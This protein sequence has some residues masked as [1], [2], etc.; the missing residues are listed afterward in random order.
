MSYRISLLFMFLLFLLGGSVVLLKSAGKQATQVAVNTSSIPTSTPTIVPTPSPSTLPSPSP[1]A[2]P[3]ITAS[4]S[5]SNQLIAFGSSG[6]FSQKAPDG[7]NGVESRI[8][9]I[10]P[11]TAAYNIPIYRVQGTSVPKVTITNTYSG[12]TVS[13]PIPKNAQPATGSDHTLAVIDQQKHIVYMMWNARWEGDHIKAGGMQEF[14]LSGTGI[15]PKNQRV[16]ASGFAGLAGMIIREDFTDPKTGKL[17]SA[18]PIRHALTM[19][20]PHELLKRN[21]FIAPAVNGDNASDNTGDIPIGTRYTFPKNADIE[22]MQLHPLTKSIARAIRDYGV[23]VNDRTGTSPYQGK[24]I[25]KIRI[26]QGLTD[27]VFG[28]S[29]DA[30]IATIRSEMATVIQKYGL[31]RVN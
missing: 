26:E 24:H 3:K 9:T 20:I 12:R 19:A 21:G 10:Q 6:P 4:I 16:S 17:S 31:Q 14:P 8:G 27:A 13:W 1:V 2:K 30:M 18:L 5:G 23:Y 11:L 22:H 29:H 25:G 7:K 15:G 28:K